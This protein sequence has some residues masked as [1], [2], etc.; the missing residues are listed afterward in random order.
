[1]GKSRGAVLQ[2]CGNK[3]LGEEG[4]GR[5]TGDPLVAGVERFLFLRVSRIDVL[6][7]IL[8]FKL[9]KRSPSLH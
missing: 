9:S 8:H 1:M 4:W 3:I 5:F 7:R 2:R 6:F